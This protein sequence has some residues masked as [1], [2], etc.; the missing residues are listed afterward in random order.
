M[1]KMGTGMAGLNPKGAFDDI[2]E[3]K[4]IKFQ[5]LDPS[6]IKKPLDIIC[7][8]YFCLSFHALT[9]AVYTMATI[10]LS[11]GVMTHSDPIRLKTGHRFLDFFAVRFNPLMSEERVFVIIVMFLGVVLTSWDMLSIAYDDLH[12]V[13]Q[14]RFPEV[15]I[16]MFLLKLFAGMFLFSPRYLTVYWIRTGTWIFLFV[17]PRFA[18][19]ARMGALVR[20]EVRKE[21]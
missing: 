13:S 19:T 7:L 2:S 5:K 1:V 21:T 16:F 9:I 4:K 8:K 6:T 15:M 12:I 10:C 11:L 14:G 18:F 3:A 17:V 20:Q